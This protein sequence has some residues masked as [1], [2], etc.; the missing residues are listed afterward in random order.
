[1]A[2]FPAVGA[3]VIFYIC[4]YSLAVLFVIWLLRRYNSLAQVRYGHYFNGTLLDIC[5]NQCAITV[6]NFFCAVD[7][8]AVLDLA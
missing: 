6:A 8:K 7:L 1:M 2:S 5:L 3:N 4:F